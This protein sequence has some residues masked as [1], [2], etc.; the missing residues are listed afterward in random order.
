MKKMPKDQ[1]KVCNVESAISRQLSDSHTVFW[2]DNCNVIATYYYWKGQC[3][4]LL[5]EGFITGSLG[6]SRKKQCSK[7]NKKKRSKKPFFSL[8]R[9]WYGYE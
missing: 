7:V 4:Y 2:D 9:G 1:F 3:N 5:S 8:Q 6:E